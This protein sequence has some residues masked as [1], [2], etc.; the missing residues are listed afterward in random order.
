V[1]DEHAPAKQARKS[2]PR[3]ARLRAG[4][5]LVAGSLGAVAAALAIVDHLT[6]DG[7]AGPQVPSIRVNMTTRAGA[8]QA[9]HFFFQ[10]DGQLV[11]LNIECDAYGTLKTVDR[12]DP[13]SHCFVMEQT[14]Y[15]DASPRAFLFTTFAKS[16][17]ARAWWTGPAHAT[18]A[19]RGELWIYLPEKP[20]GTTAIYDA[21]SGNGSSGAGGL[22][23]KGYFVDVVSGTGS[24]GPPGLQEVDLRPVAT[25]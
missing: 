10:H 18:E 25:P 19:G 23:A 7:H 3:K 2:K 24:L 20:E 15:S 12:M 22:A 9:Q 17:T 16:Q 5:A 11:Y 1:K 4:A 8:A 14:N 21:N 13:G 6:G